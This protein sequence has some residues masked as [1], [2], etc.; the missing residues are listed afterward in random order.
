MKTSQASAFNFTLGIIGYG[1]MAQAIYSGMKQKPKKTYIVDKDP[2][3][4]KK[5]APTTFFCDLE[6]LFTKSDIILIAVKPQ[7]LQQL[8]TSIPTNK[9]VCIVSILAG[10][11]LKQ[12]EQSFPPNQAI[13]RCMPNTAIRVQSGST[14]YCQNKHCRKE[15]IERLKHLFEQASLLKEI[16]EEDMNL[17]TALCASSPAFFYQIIHDLCQHQSTSLTTK[18]CQSLAS[19]SMLGA[20]KMML[21]DPRPL[22]ELINEVTSA[23]GCTDAGLQRYKKEGLPEKLTAVINDCI[24]RAKEL[25]KENQA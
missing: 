3:K 23:K 12:L 21:Q 25:G 11:T 8:V 14:A 24:H 6:T 9:N 7:H 5:N 17:F 1:N 18:D 22:Q 13:I 15:D 2:N 10:V 4:S 20:A 19:Q 16:H